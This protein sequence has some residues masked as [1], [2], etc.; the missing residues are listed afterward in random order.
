MLEEKKNLHINNVNTELACP[1]VG[2]IGRIEVVRLS[3][4]NLL[5]SAKL[6]KS[7][8]DVM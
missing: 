5:I 8:A 3:G 4:N 7:Q 6:I 1:A 2:K